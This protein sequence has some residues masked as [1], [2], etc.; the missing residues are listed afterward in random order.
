[1][2]EDVILEFDVHV[3]DMNMMF[4]EMVIKNATAR[5]RI[6]VLDDNDVTPRFMQGKNHDLFLLLFFFNI[7]VL[8][9]LL[10][11]IV[12]FKMFLR[13]FFANKKLIMLTTLKF[14]DVT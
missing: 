1:M 4:G 11:C 3:S 7:Y 14:G 12:L 5:V 2:T 10:T 13:W 8:Q 9:K 6:R